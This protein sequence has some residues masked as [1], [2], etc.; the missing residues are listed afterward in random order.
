MNFGAWH[1]LVWQKR[2]IR[3]SFHRENRLFH[4]F[5]KVFLLESLP[6]YGITLA[7]MTFSQLL[8]DIASTV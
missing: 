7:C 3:E 4:Q 8:V 2:A 6:L 5:V 1:P